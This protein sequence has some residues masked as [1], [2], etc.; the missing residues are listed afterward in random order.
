MTRLARHLPNEEFRRLGPSSLSVCL[1]RSESH[2]KVRTSGRPGMF[3]D[4]AG[5][6]TFGHVGWTGTQTVIDPE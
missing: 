2:L 3:G 1:R 5:P 6:Q 4:R